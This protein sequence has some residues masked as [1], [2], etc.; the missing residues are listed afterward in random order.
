MPPRRSGRGSPAPAA[1]SARAAR[2]TFANGSVANSIGPACSASTIDS[3]SVEQHAEVPAVGRVAG[4]R[5]DPRPRAAR[6]LSA[7]VAVDAIAQIA[8]AC[9]TRRVGSSH[10]DSVEA[11]RRVVGRHRPSAQQ[12]RARDTSR[13]AGNAHAVGHDAVA[14]SRRSSPIATSSQRIERP[15]RARGIGATRVRRC[16]LR[17]PRA[18]RRTTSPSSRRPC[19][20][21]RTPR[22][23]RSRGRA[24]GC[25]AISASYT[26]PI[27]FAGASRRQRRGTPRRARSARR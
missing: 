17:R 25:S 19:R 20:C 21:P 12:D 3:P 16:A 2:A 9:L 26:P 5:H 11:A 1:A 8:A 18:R 7:Q 10:C 24:P 23:R 27:E 4:Q 6:P 15:S 14:R 13:P 22:R